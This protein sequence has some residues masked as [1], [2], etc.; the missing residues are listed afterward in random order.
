MR[1]VIELLE[2][3][4]FI[5]AMTS[6]ELRSMA[7][8]PLKVYCGFYPTGDSLHLGNLVAII[9]L[10]WFQRCGHTP[11]AIVGGATG[12]IGDP[13]GKISER[14]LLDE[15]TINKNLAGIRKN[16]EVILDLKEAPNKAAILNNY[17]WFK[18]FS[19]LDFLR[20]V[21]KYFRVGP[22]LAKDSVKTRMSSEEGMSF[23]EFSYQ[24]LQGY[25]FLHLFDQFGVTVQLG[26]SDQW[27]NITAGTDFDPQVARQIGLWRHISSLDP[28]RRT[29][30]RQVGK[31]GYLAIA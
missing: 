31:R 4:G 24:I 12:M 30:I 19:F 28:Q 16:L 23:T 26:G 17:D 10:A 11:I 29:K 27:G 6:E 5:D 21:G 15:Q 18:Q 7:E 13:S 25:D 20:D 14:Q 22:M 9:G 2:E 1:N 3:R 8:N